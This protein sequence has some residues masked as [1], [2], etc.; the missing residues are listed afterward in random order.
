MLVRGKRGQPRHEQPRPRKRCREL[1]VP[2]AHIG[3]PVV[4]RRDAE[5]HRGTTLRRSSKR[6]GREPTDV[7]D[8]PGDT[9][10]PDAKHETVDM[11]RRKAV[12][13]S[14]SRSVHCHASNSASRLVAIAEQGDLD[15]LGRPVVPEV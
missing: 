14:W 8:L 13:A 3:D 4:H 2:L 9:K 5:D 12:G 7:L 11:E 10:R 15:T 1:V 6:L